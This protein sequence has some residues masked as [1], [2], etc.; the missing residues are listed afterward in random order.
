[1]LNLAY[2]ARCCVMLIHAP[3]HPDREAMM[4]ALTDGGEVVLLIS[5]CLL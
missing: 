5:A 1:V 3:A 2:C 4:R